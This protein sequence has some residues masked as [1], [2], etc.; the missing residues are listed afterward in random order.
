M[1]EETAVNQ[2]AWEDLTD[3]LPHINMPFFALLF[4]LATASTR[5]TGS[6]LALST[7]MISKSV[8]KIQQDEK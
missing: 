3:A 6:S 7:L 2:I 4:C 8:V 1:A 5:K